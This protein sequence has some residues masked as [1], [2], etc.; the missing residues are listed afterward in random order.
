MRKQGINWDNP[1]R[2]ASR[3]LPTYSWLPSET[4]LYYIVRVKG[5]ALNE[6]TAARRN[7]ARKCENVKCGK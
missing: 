3:V 1:I 2:H 6:V 4:L 5:I 7:S